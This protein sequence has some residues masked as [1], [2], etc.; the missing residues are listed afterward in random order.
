M[1]VYVDDMYRYPMGRYGRLRMSH[2]MAD[3]TGELLAMADSIGV[4][5]KWIQD[6]GGRTEHFD[7][8]MSKRRLAVEHGAVEVTMKELVRYMQRR[9]VSGS[10]E[11]PAS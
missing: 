6:E 8:A 9:D 5:R 11:E 4:A 7:I 1:T 10:A 2:L 3:T